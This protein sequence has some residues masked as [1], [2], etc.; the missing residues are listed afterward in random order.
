MAGGRM[1]VQALAA[2]LEVP[3]VVLCALTGSA[4]WLVAGLAMWGVCKGFYEANIFAAAFD[5]VPPEARG[6][7]TGTMNMVGWLGGAG[8]APLLVGWM[9]GWIG[10]SNAVAATAAAY[11][12]ACILMAIAGLR[13]AHGDTAAMEAQLAATRANRI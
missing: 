13:F 10:L 4:G 11:A 12:M 6:V 3:F 9:A 1:L 7:A 2:G 5:V 8:T